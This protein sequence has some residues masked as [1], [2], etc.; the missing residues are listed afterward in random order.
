M[1]LTIMRGRSS[2]K[3]IAVCPNK[4]RYL[5]WAGSRFVNADTSCPACSEAL[6][7]LVRRKY[8]VTA[9]YR[10]PSCEVI[11]RVPKES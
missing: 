6:T 9:F 11:F 2:V 8:G 5:L 3:F 10:C 7:V 4:L 1:V